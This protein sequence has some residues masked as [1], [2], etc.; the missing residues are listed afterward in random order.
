MIKTETLN[1]LQNFKRIHKISDNNL[2]IGD[3]NFVENDIDK[4]KGMTHSDKIVH[5]F[6][7]HLSQKLQL[8]ILLEYNALEKN[9]SHTPHPQE[10]VE[11]IGYT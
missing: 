5:T 2:I 8:S 3:F 11:W 9:Y 6:G 4:G 1:I 10:E 7:K